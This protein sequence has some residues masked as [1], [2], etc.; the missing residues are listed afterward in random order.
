MKHIHLVALAQAIT[1][2][3]LASGCAVDS[4]AAQ[5]PNSET[6]STTAAL[7]VC[8]ATTALKLDRQKKAGDILAFIMGDDSRV[9]P[10][11]FKKDHLLSLRGFMF[12][13]MGMGGMSIP[14]SMSIS[15][16]S[17]GTVCGISASFVRIG[18]NPAAPV[19]G[20]FLLPAA[21]GGMA[22][23][24]EALWPGI[25][26][27]LHTSSCSGAYGSTSCAIDFDP[28]P[29]QLSAPL[30]GGTGAAASAAY[31]N[32]SD[33]VTARKWTS[34]YSSCSSN[35]P[36]LMQPC[37]TSNLAAGASVSGI[38]ERASDGSSRYRCAAQ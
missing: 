18:A 13:G 10:E 21:L 17:S 4:G 12:G 31:V 8:P 20:S 16:V 26:P 38:I 7:G 24:A 5:A 15:G 30:S 34:T 37:A 6:E 23:A 25:T 3:V 33:P 35:C 28:E 19:N 1:L 11:A 36:A 2:T 29:A 22:N 27:F 14:S 32:S 9:L